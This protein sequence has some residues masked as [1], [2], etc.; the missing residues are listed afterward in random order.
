MIAPC[1]QGNDTRADQIEHVATEPDEGASAADG[2]GPGFGGEGS[3]LGLEPETGSDSSDHRCAAQPDTGVP[4][5]DEVGSSGWGSWPA[6]AVR[7]RAARGKDGSDG[8]PQ[9]KVW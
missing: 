6:G 9:E 5:A 3:K 2:D 1:Q 8:R 4:Q 7:S